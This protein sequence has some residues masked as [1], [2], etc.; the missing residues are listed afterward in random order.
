MNTHSHLNLSRLKRAKQNRYN[1]LP[2]LTDPLQ[3]TR[4]LDAFE[5]GYLKDV[6]NIWDSLEK[7]DDLIRTVVSKRKKSIGRQGWT[8]LVHGDVPAD[9]HP[10]AQAHAAALEYFYQ[11]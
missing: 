10:E 11:N 4:K 6:V 7:R 3:L 9:R 1:P 2:S 5:A 8:V